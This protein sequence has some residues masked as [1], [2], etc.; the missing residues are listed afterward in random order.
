MVVNKFSITTGRLKLSRYSS[1]IAG[2]AVIVYCQSVGE[3]IGR[4]FIGGS[5]CATIFFSFWP[6]GFLLSNLR[7]INSG[8]VSI[9]VAPAVRPDDPKPMLKRGVFSRQMLSLCYQVAYVNLGLLII[10]SLIF[11]ESNASHI[12]AAFL[13]LALLLL[14]HP[15]AKLR[16]ATKGI[17]SD[18]FQV[19]ICSEQR[20]NA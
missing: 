1:I 3:G 5:L 19:S 20:S 9:S 10:F 6:V 15:V 18:L 4:F 16:R 2:I 17:T 13:G 8:N 11:A 7:D 14:H 12:G